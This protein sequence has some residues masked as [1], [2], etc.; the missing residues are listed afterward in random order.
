MHDFGCNTQ[1]LIAQVYGGAR[2]SLD[3]TSSIGADNVRMAQRMLSRQGIAFASEDTGGVMGRKILFDTWTGET[4][5]MKVNTLR[6]AD[7]H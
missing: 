2:P 6:S 1:Q 3:S 4:V 7:W 5:V